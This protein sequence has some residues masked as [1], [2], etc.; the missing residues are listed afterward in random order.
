LTAFCVPKTGFKDRRS[1]ER[2]KRSSKFPVLCSI[3]VAFCPKLGQF[4][5]AVGH[6][7]VET[8]GFSV[9]SQ[10][11]HVFPIF[12]VSGVDQKDEQD[13]MDEMDAMDEMDEMQC[14]GRFKM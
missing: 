5:T 14:P 6:A 8:K 7:P 13:E 11:S 2:G 1:V 3:F 9:L 4:G 10:L 12:D